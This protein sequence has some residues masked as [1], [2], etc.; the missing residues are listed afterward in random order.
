[1]NPP[2][3]APTSR[4]SLPAGSTASTSSAW[5][6]FSPPR[7]TKRGG[8]STSSCDGLVE[9]GPRLVVS[10]NQ[11]GDHECLSLSPR[12]GQ[13]ALDEQDYPVAS[14]QPES[15]AMPVI[16]PAGWSCGAIVSYCGSSSTPT[17]RAFVEIGQE[18]GFARW[19]PGLDAAD[20]AA[21]AAGTSRVGRL[22]GHRRRGGDRDR[23]VLRG[24]RPPVPARRHRSRPRHGLAGSGTRHRHGAGPRAL[25]RSRAERTTG[26]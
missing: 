10:R 8:R 9:L 4:Q 2:V 21:K 13:P 15:R 12:L 24:G 25:P 18:P 17:S 23:P 20:L 11:P 22:R 6:S 3:E 16:R 19:W 5:A 14:S 26:W 7:E 1:M